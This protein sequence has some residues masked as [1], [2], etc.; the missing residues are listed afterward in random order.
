MNS[1]HPDIIDETLKYKTINKKL[2]FS[3]IPK[4]T[5]TYIENLGKEKN[6]NWGRNDNYLKK[7]KNSYFNLPYW[8]LPLNF[9]DKYPY[10]KFTKLFTIVRNPYDRILSTC[11]CKYVCK[12]IKNIKQKK[13]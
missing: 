6:L 3:H 12:F 5:G 11:L 7:L 9:I 10:E 1:D 8:H 2:K 4:T 13:I